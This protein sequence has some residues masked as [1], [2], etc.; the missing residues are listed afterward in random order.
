LAQLRIASAPGDARANQEAARYLVV[1][2]WFSRDRPKFLRY[3]TD[4][5]KSKKSSSQFA[6]ACKQALT[7]LSPDFSVKN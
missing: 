4:E 7:R 6:A 1:A 3:M 5:A 2:Y